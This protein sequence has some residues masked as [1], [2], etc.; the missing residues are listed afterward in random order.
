MNPQPKPKKW[1]SPKYR[2]AAKGQPCAMRLHGCN[3]GGETTVLAHENGGGMGTKADDYNAADMCSNC[4]DIFDMRKPG[5]DLWIMW[6]FSRARHETI[7]NRVK[8]GIISTH[9]GYELFELT[10]K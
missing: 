4:H 9:E 6:E 3:G 2:A 5:R 7:A 8:R 10:M 1:R